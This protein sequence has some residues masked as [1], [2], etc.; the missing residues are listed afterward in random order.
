MKIRLLAGCILFSS[1]ATTALAQNTD[2]TDSSVAVGDYRKR[3]NDKDLDVFRN[4]ADRQ[5][6]LV[7]KQKVKSPVELTLSD[8]AKQVFNRYRN[9]AEAINDRIKHITS[10]ADTP[11]EMLNRRSSVP[12]AKVSNVR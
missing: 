1:L 6:E 12:S 7:N 3:I 8:E 2:L 9:E 10:T 5:R 11:G 4:L